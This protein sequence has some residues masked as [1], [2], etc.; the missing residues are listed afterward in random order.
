MNWS[1]FNL[2]LQVKLFLDIFGGTTF[3]MY[4]RKK[5][6]KDSWLMFFYSVLRKAIK[7]FTTLLCIH[8]MH[9]SYCGRINKV[10][11][12]VNCCQQRVWIILI[13]RVMISERDIAVKFSKCLFLFV[14]APHVNCHLFPLWGV[15]HLYSRSTALSNSTKQPGWV[16]V[17]VLSEG[18]IDSKRYA[19][20]P[21][22]AL[23]SLFLTPHRSMSSTVCLHR[24]L[25]FTLGDGNQ[26]DRLTRL[27]LMLFV[28]NR[29]C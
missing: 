13:R 23:R 19:E 20:L 29:C 24:T 2:K 16:N 27:S 7:S 22:V 5:V 1:I 26:R 10:V 3:F 28:W 8:F 4:H 6:S 17:D 18:H 21:L 12:T 15:T 25:K 9:I 11:P 14:W